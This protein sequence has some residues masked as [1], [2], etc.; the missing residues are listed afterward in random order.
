MFPATT[1]ILIVDD[2][3]TMRKLIR[4]AVTGMGYTVMDEA[5]DGQ[6]GWSR[7]QADPKIGLVISDWTLPNCTGLEFL[8][9]VRSDSRF[10]TLPFILLTA[11]AEATQVTEAVQAGV[12]NY[13]VKPF[14]PEG[15]KSKLEQTYQ[16][17]VKAA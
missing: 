1:K 11:E 14:T 4:K 16:R 8:R 10:R 7:L 5:E 12:S 6:V 17:I 9:R 3:M 15:L 13:I 2:M